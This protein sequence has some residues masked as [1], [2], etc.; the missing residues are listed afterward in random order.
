MNQA[1]PA[2]CWPTPP[3]ARAL[4]AALRRGAL[5]QPAIEAWAEH[6]APGQVDPGTVRL[7]PLVQENASAHGVNTAWDGRLAARRRSALKQVSRSLESARTAV[8]LLEGGGIEALLLKGIPLAALYYHSPELRPMAD[9]DVLVRTAAVPEA[10]DA[11]RGIG[12][13]REDLGAGA[14]FDARGAHALALTDENGHVIDLHWH[15]FDGCFKADDDDALW[16]RSRSWV[17]SGHR[18]RALSAADQLLHVCVHGHRWMQIPSCRWVADAV[19]ILRTATTEF[20]WDSVLR[21]ARSRSFTAVLR[22]ALPYLCHITGESDLVPS[23]VLKDLSRA[24][25]SWTERAAQRARTVAPELRG[26]FA[27]MGLHADSYARLR[28]SGAISA[29]VSGWREMARRT[30]GVTQLRDLPLAFLIRGAR[31]IGQILSWRYSADARA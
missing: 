4:G 29:G 25:V 20:D 31:R 18:V 9:I 1:R 10:I 26:G 24:R 6:F 5:A 14:S 27:S 22:E 2:D 15:V 17:L 11:L 13:R 19:T 12:I 16:A 28:R 8:A 30:W 21:E 23:P 7:L 3:Q